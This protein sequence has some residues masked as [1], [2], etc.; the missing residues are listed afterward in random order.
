MQAV[1]GL[2]TSGT[3]TPSRQGIAIAIMLLAVGA[4]G[5]SLAAGASDPGLAS[6][7]EL[8]SGV[9]SGVGA[10]GGVETAGM[11]KHRIACGTMA[12]LVSFEAKI[13]AI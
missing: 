1:A 9:G 11:S 8:E 5:H 10:A 12:I 13:S 2:H 7:G 4:M 6:S 3:S